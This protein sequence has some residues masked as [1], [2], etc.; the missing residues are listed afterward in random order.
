M[1]GVSGTETRIL[2]VILG[3]GQGTRL[4]PL[5]KT[6]CKAAVPIGGKYRLI[7]VPLSNCI[8]SGLHHIFLLAQYLGESLQ[9]H[10]VQTYRFDQFAD[11]FI[12][13][14][15]AQQT[16]TDFMWYEGTADAVRKNIQRI[17]R[18]RADHVLIL[19]ADH[20]YRMDYRHLIKYH[21]DRRAD[22]TLAG[23]LVGPEEAPRMGIIQADAAMQVQALIEKP[24]DPKQLAG[25]ERPPVSGQEKRYLASMGIYL[26]RKHFLI[27]L[28]KN[29][30]APDFGSHII[31]EAVQKAKVV[32]F[33]FDG[34]WV[35]VGTVA[36]FYDASMDFVSPLPRFDF[37][38][39]KERVFTRPRYLPPAKFIDSKITRC[40]IGEG[41]IIDSVE[42]FDSIVGIRSVI[43]KQC[44]IRRSVLM[45]NDYYERQF[46]TG[47][48]RPRI[49]PRVN[50]E[51]AIVDKNVVIGEGVQIQGTQ[52]NVN[53]DA[54]YYCIRDGIVVI[55]TNTVVPAGTQIIA[56]K[57]AEVEDH[58]G[59]K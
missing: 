49:G 38:R 8:H 43:D 28:L 9:R 48:I 42:I 3:G 56:D 45:G 32:A 51:R 17:E 35:D 36:S 4:F 16:L 41:S 21:T 19:S 13:I 22:L 6:R 29:S 5:T 52:R 53:L 34:Y 50:I 54:E 46:D 58:G 25:L 31:P 1:D 55:P 40:V 26:F 14:L 10:I 44:Q 23:T 20:L 59:C 47:L 30:S 27:D 37:Y 11:G 24:K 39:E 33:P 18:F 7:D 57:L 2:T 15:S 12:E